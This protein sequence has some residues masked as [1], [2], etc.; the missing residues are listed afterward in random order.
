MS[1]PSL[2]HPQA[3]YFTTAFRAT[4]CSSKIH[5]SFSEKQNKDVLFVNNYLVLH[6][7]SGCLRHL[8]AAQ[9]SGFRNLVK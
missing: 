8:G 5:F 1:E 6:G 9:L 2:I 3:W 7:I 4:N